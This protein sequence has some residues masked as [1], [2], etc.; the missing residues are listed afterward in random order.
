MC[1]FGKFFEKCFGFFVLK[2][3]KIEK[4]SVGATFERCCFYSSQEIRLA[5]FLKSK[6]LIIIFEKCVSGGGHI[7]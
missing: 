5:T 7:W 1:M 4:C 6:S 2:K 3:V